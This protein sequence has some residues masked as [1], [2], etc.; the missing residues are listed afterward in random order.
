MFEGQTL[1]THLIHACI[2]EF[3]KYKV[4]VTKPCTDVSVSMHGFFA[5][6][7]G[8]QRFASCKVKISGS[9]SGPPDEKSFW[10][11]RYCT[12]AQ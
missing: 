8:N 1:S 6:F 4:M 9:R 11:I 7:A 10:G 2:P 3:Y 5:F 12:H